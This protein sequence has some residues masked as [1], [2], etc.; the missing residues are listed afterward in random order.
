MKKY[1]VPG[2]S[3]YAISEDGRVWSK[4]QRGVKRPPAEQKLHDIWQKTHGKQPK[5]RE[6]KLQ[7]AKNGMK[8]IDLHNKGKITRFYIEKL[9]LLVFG[10]KKQLNY[11]KNSELSVPEK[12]LNV[13]KSKR[14][15]LQLNLRSSARKNKQKPQREWQYASK[16]GTGRKQEEE[17]QE[18]ELLYEECPHKPSIHEEGEAWLDPS[19]D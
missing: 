9:L 1:P 8:F 17:A 18:L 16:F 4:K 10:T 12:Q 3:G 19:Y 5:P 2:F 11:T 7:T 14:Q 15:S 13:R 6:L